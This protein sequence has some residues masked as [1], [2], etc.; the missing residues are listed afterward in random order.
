MPEEDPQ[1]VERKAFLDR[2]GEVVRVTVESS[3]NFSET[4]RQLDT[5][6]RKTS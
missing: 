2:L 6:F 4:A 3:Q 5:I 1:Q